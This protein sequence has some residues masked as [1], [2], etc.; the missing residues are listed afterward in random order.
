M[1]HQFHE[2]HPFDYDRFVTG[3]Q[4]MLW[5]FFKKMVIADRLGLIAGRVFDNPGE[6]QGLQTLVGMYCFAFQIFCD[7]SGYSDIAIGARVMGFNLML[8]FRRPYHA[9]TIVDFW[10]HWHIS[11]S[12]WFRDYVYVPLGGNRGPRWQWYRNTMIVFALSG[13]WHGAAWTYV[14]WGLMHG[15]AVVLFLVTAK[16]Y[17]GALGLGKV[18]P[19]VGWLRKR[20]AIVV[21]FHFVLIT[22]VYFRAPVDGRCADHSH[23]SVSGGRLAESFRGLASPYELLLSFAAVM[24]LK[25]RTRLKRAM[26]RRLVLNTR[27]FGS[28]N[29]HGSAGASRMH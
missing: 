23:Q 6:F 11:L 20:L 14:V 13:L 15:L 7:F 25:G 10:R 19:G 24:A 28:R 29:A 4:L 27:S 26:L 5:G 17:A 3:L 2:Y 16:Y 9:A 8:N 21:T 18:I 1:L 22:W 12:T